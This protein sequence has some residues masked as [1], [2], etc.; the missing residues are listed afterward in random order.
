M[1][2][3]ICGGAGFIGTNLV[4]VLLERESDQLIVIDRLSY[5]SHPSAVTFLKSLDGVEF[6]IRDIGD[7]AFIHSMLRQTRPDVLINLAAETHVD[8]SIRA[9]DIFIE[10]NINSTFRL[11]QECLRYWHECAVPDQK[12]FRFLHISTD[13]VYGSIAEGEESASE[14]SA[15]R[16]TNPYSATKAAA[17]HMISAFQNTYGF[18][19]NILYFT[20]NYGPYQHS[21][22]LIPKT[23]E[24]AIAGQPIPIYGDGSQK[25]TWIN[26]KDSCAAVLS[27]IEKGNSG[28]HYNF[29]GLDEFRNLDLVTQICTILDKLRP[30]RGTQTY[31]S[32]ITFV[33][34]RP[35]HDS[36]YA[37]NSGRAMGELDWTPR[38]PF[39][40]GLFEAVEWYLEQHTMGLNV[41]Q[42]DK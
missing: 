9:P 22:K 23:V 24:S 13:E 11:L 29:G 12:S 3:I 17:D 19:A 41:R 1:V 34:D 2:I 21:E 39:R 27:V 36:R 31:Q 26:V 33:E 10:N 16:P 25:R 15:Y 40:S 30:L 18:P 5:A 20:N 37:I 28:S 32:L 4:E 7:R 35:G 42:I 38:I 6:H 14:G 8:N